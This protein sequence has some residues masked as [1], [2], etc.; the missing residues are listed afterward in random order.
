MC[1]N[2]F[3][4]YDIEKTNIFEDWFAGI[5]N[6][7]DKARI[8]ARI[9]RIRLGNLGDYKRLDESLYELRFFFGKGLEKI[10]M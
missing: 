5:K 10:R 9:I 6:P 4:E 1:D 7:K 3:M 8:L 2:A